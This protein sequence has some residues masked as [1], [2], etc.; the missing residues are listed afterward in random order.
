MA[1]ILLAKDWLWGLASLH[2]MMPSA[3]AMPVSIGL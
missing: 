2:G 3:A 1:H